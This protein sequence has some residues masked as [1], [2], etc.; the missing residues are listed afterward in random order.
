MF[1]EFQDGRQNQR[2]PP[3]SDYVAAF[4][5]KQHTF[6]FVVLQC[7]AREIWVDMWKK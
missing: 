5:L 1:Y 7:L 3:F 4:D 2:W 6:R